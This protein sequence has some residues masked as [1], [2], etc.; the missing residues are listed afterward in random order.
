MASQTVPAPLWL[1][2]ILNWDGNCPDTEQM[3]TTAFEAKDYL[4]CIKDL[5]KRGVEPKSYINSL[6]NVCTPDLDASS[7]DF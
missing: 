7:S 3:L 6:D 5:K 2:N 1:N 4:E